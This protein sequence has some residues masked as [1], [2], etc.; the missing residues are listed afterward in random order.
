M[1]SHE[2]FNV[3]VI[4]ISLKQKIQLYVLQKYVKICFK[5][6][7]RNELSTNYTINSINSASIANFDSTKFFTVHVDCVISIKKKRFI[8]VAIG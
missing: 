2:S 5:F 3:L 6:I 1:D 8:E 4:Y 7:K